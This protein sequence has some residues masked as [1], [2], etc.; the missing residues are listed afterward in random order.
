MIT[1]GWLRF[2]LPRY[3]DERWLFPPLVMSFPDSAVAGFWMLIAEPML[4]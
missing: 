1:R 2:L 4:G 3:I